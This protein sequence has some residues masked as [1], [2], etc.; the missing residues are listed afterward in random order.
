[1]IDIRGLAYVVVETTDLDRW[2][3]FAESVLGMA[4]SPSADGGLYVRM[5]ERQFRFAVQPGQRD[6]YVVSG[7]EVADQAAFEAGVSVLKADVY[8]R[9]ALRRVPAGL[10]QSRPMH[11]ADHVARSHFFLCFLRFLTFFVFFC[12]ARS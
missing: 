4:T 11:G 12:P 2:R 1:M 5:D 9:Q 6:A 7:W 10:G 8:K 3:V